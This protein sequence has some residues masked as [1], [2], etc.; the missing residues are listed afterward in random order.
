MADTLY[1]QLLKRATGIGPMPEPSW[2]RKI[3]ETVTGYP[4]D[5]T[6][7][8]SPLELIGAAGGL[9]VG[10][11]A[12]ARRF[13]G[14]YR[15]P[16]NPIYSHL[17]KELPGIRKDPKHWGRSTIKDVRTLPSFAGLSPDTVSALTLAQQKYPRLFAHVVSAEQHPDKRFMGQAFPVDARA[18]ETMLKF[19]PNLKGDE[20]LNTVAHELAHSAQFLRRP[21]SMLENYSLAEDSFGYWNNPFEQQARRAGENFVNRVRNPKVK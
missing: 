13:T 10:G 14:A 12:V 2:P 19:A 17:D 15:P 7:E 11:A 9:G 21:N 5:P 16:Y 20:A 6:R 3:L 18:G 1:D 4:A 8:M